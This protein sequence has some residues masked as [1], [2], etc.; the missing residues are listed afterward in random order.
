LLPFLG[1]VL[2][3]YLPRRHWP[4]F[5]SLPV[6]TAAPLTAV[7][8]LIVAGVTGIGAFMSYTDG[9]VAK[10]GELQLAIAERQVRGELPETTVVST[11]PMAVALLSPLAFMFL[12]PTG[13]A[14]TYFVMSSFVRALVWLTDSAM[15]D[16]VL[17]ALDHAVHA[18]S[19]GVRARVDRHAREHAEGARV[20][21]RVYEGTWA[22][23]DADY[24]VVAS[25]QKPEW[26]R[27]TTVMTRDDCFTLGAPFDLS[28]PDGLRTVYPLTRQRQTEV[29]RSAV[30]YEM[31]R[32][33]T[34]NTTS[35]S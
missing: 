8:T 19:K 16:P 31:P 25:R 22:G 6:D 2:V 34:T 21:D 29:V 32:V 5:Q 3:S 23:L 1:A 24:V 28:T 17:T 15:G 18:T 26:V 20:P 14:A 10:S 35:K 12:T 33:R 4:R 7:L 11:G 9:V 27:G 13:A 30:Q